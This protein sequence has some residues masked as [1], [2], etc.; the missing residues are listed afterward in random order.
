MPSMRKQKEHN[1]SS[2]FDSGEISIRLYMIA[3]IVMPIQSAS[4][5]PISLVLPGTND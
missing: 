5:S 3:E 1:G 2:Y 4:I